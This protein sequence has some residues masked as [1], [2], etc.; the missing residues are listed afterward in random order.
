MTI[1]YRAKSSYLTILIALVFSVSFG[2]EL[3]A[4][5]LYSCETPNDAPLFHT[6][7]PNTG[8]TLS[9]VPISLQGADEQ[10]RG[11]NGLAKDPTTGVCWI[12]LSPQ[13]AGGGGDGG[14]A[15]RILATIDHETGVATYVGNTMERIAG[16]AFNGNGNTL[17]GITGDG[18][19]AFIPKIVTLSKSNGSASFVQNL[20]DDDDPGETIAF[21]PL[22]GLLYRMSGS[23]DIL[24]VDWIFESINPSNMD[25]S[26][27]TLQGDTTLMFEQTALVHRDGNV[28]L[29]AQRQRGGTIIPNALHSITT[30]G[31]I[32]FIGEM[33]HEAKGL[34]FDCGIPEVVAEVPTLSEWGLIVMASVMG[35]VGFMILRRMKAAA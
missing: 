28:L 34:A 5:T 35:I 19:G 23:G 27:I 10:L 3:N 22:D 16:I 31:D 26:Q 11:C 1:K 21:N 24:N 6:I 25:V 14:N 13:G 4:Q 8:A 2:I 7:D 30:N 15:N 9:T 12:I 17:Y 18:D 29:S 32:T 20:D 33:D